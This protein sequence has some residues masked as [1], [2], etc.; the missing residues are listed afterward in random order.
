MLEYDGLPGTFLKEYKNNIEKVNFDDIRNVASRYLAEEKRVVL[1][2][3]DEKRFEKPL[4][5]IG[6]FRSAGDTAGADR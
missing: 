3:G 1:V 4:S 5:T 2:L 6:T